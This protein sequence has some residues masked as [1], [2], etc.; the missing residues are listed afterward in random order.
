M[1]GTWDAVLDKTKKVCGASVLVHALVQ[2]TLIYPILV[3]FIRQ[4]F[5]RMLGG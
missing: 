5:N 1:L 3:S 4:G 2:A